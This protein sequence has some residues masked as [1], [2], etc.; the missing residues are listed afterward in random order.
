M[1]KYLLI[2][3]E[4][5]KLEQK[6]KMQFIRKMSGYDSIKKGKIER[7]PGM[8]QDLNGFKFGTNTAIIPYEKK[9]R[10]EQIFRDFKIDM[11]TLIIHI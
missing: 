3:Y 8:L 11:K 2:T 9:E 5:S 10:A 6:A 7:K 4:I 1:Q